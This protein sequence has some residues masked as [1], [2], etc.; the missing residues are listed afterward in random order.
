VL[1]FVLN[2]CCVDNM[3]CIDMLNDHGI[4]ANHTLHDSR[5]DAILM[6]LLKG[7]CVSTSS[8]SC[9]LIAQESL[10]TAHLSYTL[11]MLLLNAYEETQINAH[12]FALCCA[13]VGL[14]PITN[15][16]GRELKKELKQSLKV[17]KPVIECIDVFA[18]INKLCWF[19]IGS[20]TLLASL[21]GVQ[22][23]SPVKD[24][25]CDAII[26]H[27][28]TSACDHEGGSLCNS[29]RSAFLASLSSSKSH[30]LQL[31]ILEG[32]LKTANRKVFSHILHVLNISHSPDNP[33]KMFCSLLRSHC[34]SLLVQI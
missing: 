7:M 26:F 32:V 31:Y 19:G 30:S 28:V 24:V 14:Y 2:E 22:V 25:G 8:S 18:I 6:H 29:T 34:T 9:K 1:A 27:L 16:P 23:D 20:L 21:H 12:N 17:Q 15:C 11:C 5:Q 33:I 3:F 10:S 13:S 4:I